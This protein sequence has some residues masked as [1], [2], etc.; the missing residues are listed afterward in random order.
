MAEPHEMVEAIVVR[1]G[2]FYDGGEP[3]WLDAHTGEPLRQSDPP[4]GGG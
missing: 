3:G 4:P 2:G 1:H